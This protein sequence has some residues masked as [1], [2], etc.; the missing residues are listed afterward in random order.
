MKP[1]ESTV[2]LAKLALAYE[3]AFSVYFP[4]P[5]KEMAEIS[6]DLLLSQGIRYWVS[7]DGISIICVRCGMTSHNPS[8]VAEKY[9]GFCHT[10]LEQENV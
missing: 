6:R 7:Q 1:N 8:D 4:D 2:R 3:K 9:C 10:F 5:A